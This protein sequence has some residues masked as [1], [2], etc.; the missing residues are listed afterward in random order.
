MEP[1][2][3]KR[4]MRKELGFFSDVGDE[5]DIAYLERKMSRI[6]E[7]WRMEKKVNVNDNTQNKIIKELCN[8]FLGSGPLQE[9]LNDPEVTEI[10]VNGPNKV[11]VEKHGRKVIT[12]IKFDDYNHL[13]YIIERM[14][15]PSGR[16][17]DE[18]YPY[19][20]FSLE[21]GSR[22]NV[23]IPPLAVDGPIVTIRKMLYSINKV[24]DLVRLKTIDERMA[25][26]LVGCIRAKMNI[27][28][29]GA[30]GSGKTT[31]VE[32]LSNYIDREERIITIEDALELKLR[33]EHL[34]R[35]LT[36]PPNIEGRGEIPIRDL[37]I[38]SLRMRPTRIILGEI[39]G[40]EAMDYLQALN[41]GHSGSLAVLHA[42]T[43]HDTITRLETMALYAG[44][45]LPDWAIRKQIASGLD[46][47]VQHEQFM[48][49]TRRIT[50]ITEALEVKHG[51]MLLKDIFRFNVEGVDS[52]GRTHGKFV[53]AGV[54]DFLPVFKK[55]GVE[56]N[57]D[58]FKE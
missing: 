40:A 38:N 1:K 42:S 29:S 7:L 16:R 25:E 3:I 45:N 8:D 20:D 54:P 51:E 37:F 14:I 34:V 15:T 26:F 5:I 18:S 48:D 53:A 35:L 33:Q 28:F 55:R 47:I 4:M 32:V 58:I 23:I 50:Y 13:R 21:D 43:P 6:F 2:D 24:E 49:G 39:R 41:S 19:A 30:T 9:L 11:Y 44:L 56:I 36:R 57:P 17:L 31:T 12:K 10:M 52:S 22:V 46:L 27:V